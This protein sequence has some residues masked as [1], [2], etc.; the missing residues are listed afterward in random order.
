VK[1]PLFSRLA[2]LG[3]IAL[4]GV[5]LNGEPLDAIL[6]RMNKDSK[7]FSSVSAGMHQV[8]YTAVLN[9][10]TQSDGEMH[11]RSKGGFSGK[12]D[13]NPPDPRVIW[14]GGQK[15]KIYYPNAKQAQE[16]QVGQYLKYVSQ[17]LLFGTSGDDL[18][19]AY[20]ITPAGTENVGSKPATHLVLTPKS[21]DL[22][23]MIA[24]LEVWI[25]EGESYPIQEKSTEPSGNSH[26][27]TFHDV[28]INPHL[29][30]SAFE[31]RMPR[32][33]KVISQK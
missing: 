15:A 27:F 25:W 19:K 13:Y 14:F 28:K 3:A 24:K 8:D 22:G 12:L 21:K 20:E 18:K 30:D 31:L 7:K 26:L 1:P 10:S 9:E 32:D 4:A 6:S 17:F 5:R 29:P 16:M 11:I 2:V 23:K 33:T